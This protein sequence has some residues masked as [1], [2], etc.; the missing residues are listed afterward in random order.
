M[1]ETA[2]KKREKTARELIDEYSADISREIAEWQ[3]IAE[4]GC[5]DP[6]WSDGCNMS[7]IKNHILYYKR[8][9]AELCEE[10]G[11]PLP[12]EFF[13]PTPPDVSPNY[14][15]NITSDNAKAR[16]ARITAGRSNCR[17]V[18]EKPVYVCDQLNLL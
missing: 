1:S 14:M 6:F 3:D 4:N 5:N 18:T 9:I 11:L 16:L 13:L 7:L 17:I 8:I 2:K 15:A 10:N 12:S